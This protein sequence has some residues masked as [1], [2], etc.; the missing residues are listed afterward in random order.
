MWHPEEIKALA[1]M[2]G[3]AKSTIYARIKRGWSEAQIAQGYWIYRAPVKPPEI[4]DLMTNGREGMLVLLYEVINSVTDLDEKLD[5]YK[6]TCLVW[7]ELL[8]NKNEICI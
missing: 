7:R 5:Y 1:K 6:M 8:E 2:Q 3:V 4:W